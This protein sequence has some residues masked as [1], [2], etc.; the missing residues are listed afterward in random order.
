MK[1]TEILFKFVAIRDP[2][3]EES[4]SGRTIRFDGGRD[5]VNRITKL[6]TDNVSLEDARRKISNDFMDSSAY[7]LRSPRWQLFLVHQAEIQRILKMSE[8]EAQFTS[9]FTPF[10]QQID[11]NITSLENFVAS[12]VFKRLKESLWHSYYSNIALLD[13]R[14]QDRPVLEFWLRFWHFLERLVAQDD[15]KE[16]IKDFS[17]WSLVTPNQLVRAVKTVDTEPLPDTEDSDT[18]EAARKKIAET[19]KAIAQL[20]TTRA[21][22]IKVFHAKLAEDARKAQEEN[23][24][25]KTIP[26]SGGSKSRRRALWMLTAKEIGSD[27]A[28]AL[29]RLGI[30][31]DLHDATELDALLENQEAKLE[32]EIFQLQRTKRVTIVR[33][34]PVI[35]SRKDV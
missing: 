32:S 6:I 12:D 24:G 35:V 29:D 34:V 30:S 7:V 16:L 4:T 13:R 11:P 28:N 14:P 3:I 5:W 17:S 23:Q 22:I 25:R 15:F 2:Q 21:Q 1:K 18:S 26:D 10:L 8:N 19:R 9:F 31:L 33:G 20:Q 27:A